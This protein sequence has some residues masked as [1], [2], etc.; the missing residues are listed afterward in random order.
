LSKAHTAEAF[1]VV[2]LVASAGGMNAIR[3]LLSSLPRSFSAAVVVVQH[4]SPRVF[5]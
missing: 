3:Q 5:E 2:G 4:T 1:W